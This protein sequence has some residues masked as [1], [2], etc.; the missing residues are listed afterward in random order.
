MK[1][2]V[3]GATGF[4]GFHV[5]QRLVAQG[6]EVEA[7][8]RSE[9]KATGLK[10]LGVRLIF[11]RLNELKKAAISLPPAEAV[12]HLGGIIKAKNPQAFMTINAEGTRDLLESLD[13]SYLQKFVFISSIS[14]RGPNLMWTGVGQGPVSAYGRSKKRGEEIVRDSSG[15]FHI[16]VVRPPIVYGPGDQ[17]TLTLFKMFALG[18]FPLIAHQNQRV[19]F[20][21]VDDLVS[22]IVDAVLSRQKEFEL[23]E[24]DDGHRGYSWQEVVASAQPLYPKKIRMIAIPAWLASGVATANGILSRIF[25][26]QAFYTRGKY[27]ESLAGSWTYAYYKTKNFTTLNDGFK[28][29]YTWYREKGWVR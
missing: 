2:L 10:N 13:L 21:Y 16:A 5:V 6:H 26:T 14:A 15:R 20:I 11:G 27:K 25:H 24:P 17:T 18:F 4:I 23:I 12:I 8:V 1:I 22:V 3:T 9:S 29:A 28:K 19:S 7:L